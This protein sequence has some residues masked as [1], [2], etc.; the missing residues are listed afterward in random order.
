MNIQ[1]FVWQPRRTPL[2][3]ARRLLQHSLDSAVRR[4]SDAYGHP[5]T[6]RCVATSIAVVGSIAYDRHTSPSEDWAGDESAGAA[7]A[8]AFEPVL[9]SLGHA[10]GGAIDKVT[11]G[12]R[13]VAILA[14]AHGPATLDLQSVM[15]LPGRWCVAAWDPHHVVVVNGAATG[16]TLWWTD[17]P[18]GWAVGSLARPL[19]DLV[20]RP[21]VLDLDRSALAVALGYVA[22]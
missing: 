9:R 14:S 17:G 8:G 22:G 1:L 12:A 21:G 13:R 5:F 4:F 16:R 15:A 18:Q 6:A 20:A 2:E 7:C 11:L 10:P 19:L 3:E